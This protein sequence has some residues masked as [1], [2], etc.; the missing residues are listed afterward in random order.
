MSMI[1][2]DEWELILTGNPVINS[3]YVA[4]GGVTRIGNKATNTLP[5]F[6]HGNGRTDMD[7][8]YDIANGQ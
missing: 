5:I 8:V 2:Q 7:W 4:S 6:F 1:N 3:G